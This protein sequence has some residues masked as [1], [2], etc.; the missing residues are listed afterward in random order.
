MFDMYIE[1]LSVLDTT[2]IFSDSVTVLLTSGCP[3]L[4]KILNINV[5]KSISFYLQISAFGI[6]FKEP[7][8]YLRLRNV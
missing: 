2:S 5:V 7:T 3:L 4:K 6:L 1:I 8:S